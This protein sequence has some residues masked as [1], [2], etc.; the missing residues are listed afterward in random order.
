VTRTKDNFDTDVLNILER[1]IEQLVE[2]GIPLDEATTKMSAAFIGSLSDSGELI[3]TSLIRTAPKMLGEHAI[4]NERFQ[5]KLRDYWADVF[6]SHYAIVDCAE[7]FGSDFTKKNVRRATISNALVFQALIRLH[8]R[9]CRIALEVHW[10]LTGGFPA[11]ALARSRT[12]HE[13]AVTMNVI[14]DFGR[15]PEF[16]DLA[17]RFLLHHHITNHSDALTYQGLAASGEHKPY[18]SAD[19]ARLERRRNRLIG[20]FGRLYA[21]ASY[22]WAANL[23]GAP[24][25]FKQLESLSGI[26]QLRSYYK[27][28]SHEV[29]SDSKG[30]ALNEESLDGI[31]TH[32]STGPTLIGLSTPAQLSLISLHQCC[33]SLAANGADDASPRDLIALKAIG[34]LLE[35]AK[36]LCAD[37]EGRLGDERESHVRRSVA[38]HGAHLRQSGR[39][40]T[41]AV[42]VVAQHQPRLPLAD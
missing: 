35:R 10:L 40:P 15:K 13:L 4:M 12:L 28:A 17:E 9:A 37:V 7:E 18:T 21:S 1:G 2:R 3:A 42:R 11:G 14:G 5:R 33:A 16:L 30:S 8:A 34:E 31:R 22:G 39:R 25:D 29:H 19:M 6:D 27:W 32:L 36:T 41:V 20:R 23:P 38:S 26:D 24:R